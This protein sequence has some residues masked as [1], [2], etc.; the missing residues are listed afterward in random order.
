MQ[1]YAID[2]LTR[3]PG[4]L[5]MLGIGNSICCR[6]RLSNISWLL[7]EIVPGFVTLF[8]VTRTKTKA[9]KLLDLVE[10]KQ[11]IKTSDLDKAGIP[12]NYLSRLVKRGQLRKIEQ[13][14]Y[15]TD[16]IA[17]SEHRSLL[18][19]SRKVPKSVICLLSALRFHDIG[20]QSPREVW[21]AIKKGWS[22]KIN[23]PPVRVVWFSGNALE[24][25]AQ[26]HRIE[27]GTITVFNPAKTVADCF[28]FRHKIGMDVALEALRE[29][30]RQKKASVDELWQAAKICRVAN[31]M[32]PY[33][34]SL[35]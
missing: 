15:T 28:K 14:L 32:K 16:K 7:I 1:C 27:G 6:T 34:E 25:G 18:E 4:I 5:R 20:T 24:F 30:R 8:H 13:G 22:P 26:K 31:V 2:L 17:P 29:C 3:T 21:I 19:V 10:H 9:Q 33:M 35:F 11:V 23:Y 12:R